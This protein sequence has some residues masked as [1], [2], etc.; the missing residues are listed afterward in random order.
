MNSN[1]YDY[2][3]AGF[4]GFL[5]RSIDEVSQVNLDAAGP[6]SRQLR[7]DSAQISGMLGDKF[8]VGN[9][10][11][12]GVNGRIDIVEGKTGNVVVRIGSLDD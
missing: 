7:Y 10:L 3:K 8:Q 6:N 5:S 11:I 1:D 4:D 12:D 9:I 2:E